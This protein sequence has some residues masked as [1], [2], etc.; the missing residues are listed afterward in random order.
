MCRVNFTLTNLTKQ[1]ALEPG[2]CERTG[3]ESAK[4]RKQRGTTAIVKGKMEGPEILTRLTRQV[5]IFLKVR[6]LR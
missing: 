2:Q 1:T 3:E 6:L 5:H 4:M